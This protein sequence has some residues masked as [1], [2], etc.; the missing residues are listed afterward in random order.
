[1]ANVYELEIQAQPSIYNP[2]ERNMRI[3]FAEPEREINKETGVLLMLPAYEN[4]D[5]Y[6]KHLKVFSDRY[7]MVTVQCD[8]FGFEF[9]ESEYDTDISTEMLDEKLSTAELELLESNFE[10]YRHILEGKIFE[11][12]INLQEKPEYFNDM[13]LMQ[14]MDHLRA[15]KVVLD[16][17][18]DNGYQINENRIYAYG[19]SHGAYLA[20]L[21]NAFCPGM[22]RAIVDNSAYLTPYYLKNRREI[23]IIE[24]GMHIR[25]VQH[26]KASEY[27]EDDE[28]L[29][30][31]KLYQ[32][33][34]NKAEI[35][36]FAGETDKMTTLEEKKKFINHIACAKV[37]TITEYCIEKIRFKTTDNGLGADYLE[38]YHYANQIHMSQKEV[39]WKKKK[40][41]HTIRFD[42]VTY[43]TKKFRYDVKWEDGMPVLY[44]ES[45]A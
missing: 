45:I 1:M 9:M 34:E 7:N 10:K 23:D 3:R 5:I 29:D 6:E 4:T 35:L 31:T 43:Q 12:T 37:E 11:Q 30:I 32:Q 16:I 39:E 2:I 15:L 42:D 36:C 41:K 40:I 24:D 8:Y 14:A 25:Q 20:Y 18:A 21:C 33:F 27:I 44:R 38:L 22:F 19:V 13:G 26:Y 28:I 17:I